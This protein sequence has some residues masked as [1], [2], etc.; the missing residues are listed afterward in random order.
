MP[1]LLQPGLG[2]GDLLVMREEHC[3][4]LKVLAVFLGGQSHR[5]HMLV[6]LWEGSAA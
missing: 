5:R 2:T 1:G 3:R 4:L 6:R